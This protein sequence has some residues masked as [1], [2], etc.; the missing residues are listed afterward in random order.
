MVPPTKLRCTLAAPWGSSRSQSKSLFRVCV[1]RY[2]ASKRCWLREDIVI[3][4]G[5]GV[6]VGACWI[7]HASM[8]GRHDSH[9]KGAGKT[10][11]GALAVQTQPGDMRRAP[12]HLKLMLRRV[13]GR[14]LPMVLMRN[15]GR[16]E[17]V[18][19]SL[20]V[21]ALISFAVISLTAL[22]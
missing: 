19:Y 2:D 7:K 5:P 4:G 21:A 10:G 20:R 17:K 13:E 11:Q 3:R 15:R 14:P 9:Q 1:I 22:D 6:F 18:P 16:R 8:E 12:L